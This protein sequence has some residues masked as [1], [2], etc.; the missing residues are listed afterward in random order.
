MNLLVISTSHC[1]VSRGS[2]PLNTANIIMIPLVSPAERRP[3][4]RSTS[5]AIGSNGLIVGCEVLNHEI[6]KL[7]I[8]YS[9]WE[10]FHSNNFL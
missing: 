10:F 5:L 2:I 9:N 6:L 4:S 7:L 1:R 3:K 8:V